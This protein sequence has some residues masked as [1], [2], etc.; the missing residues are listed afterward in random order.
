[1]NANTKLL[2]TLIEQMV[3]KEVK[4][5]LPLLLQELLTKDA[6][7]DVT[8]SAPIP[9]KQSNTSLLEL[10]SQQEP[11]PRQVATTPKV[12]KTYT[13]DPMINAILNET[14]NDLSTRESGRSPY[15]GMDGS[16][17]MN[18]NPDGGMLNE[19]IAPSHQQ[20]IATTDSVLD[21]KGKDPAVDNLMK[22]DFKAIL[23]KS[24]KK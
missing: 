18:S 12:A 2:K 20:H 9:R 5:Q 10:M 16:L 15:V 14:V 22:W 24:M 4:K 13:K 11:Q 8:P 21:F 23:A 6:E 17:S 7:P 3:S 1:M 19:A